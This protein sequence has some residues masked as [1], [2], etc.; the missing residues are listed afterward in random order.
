MNLFSKM[1]ALGVGL[2]LFGV[3]LMMLLTGILP[4]NSANEGLSIM[5]FFIFLIIAIAI[6]ILMGLQH[7]DFETKNPHIENFYSE[8]EIDT[9]NK[10]FSVMVTIGVV[11]ILIG[12]VL[13]IGLESVFP[14][15]SDAAFSTIENTYE[16]ITSSAF[17]FIICI[18][19]VIFIYAGI[20]KDKYNIEEYN[21][22]HDKESETY[23]ISQL[24]S[25]VCACIMLIAV[26]IYLICGFLYDEWGMP[27]VVVFPIFGILCGIASIIIKVIHKH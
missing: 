2:I 12:V 20:H 14:T 13:L 11:L 10:K 23:K 15:L 3:S 1:M 19:T 5:V 6:F 24:K 4:E 26:I 8:E 22:S 7:G 18:S 27:S 9:F 25:K 17:L 16:A 21:L